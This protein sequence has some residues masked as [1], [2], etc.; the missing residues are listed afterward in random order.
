MRHAIGLTFLAAMTLPVWA[1][2]KPAEDDR[3]YGTWTFTSAKVMGKE[4]P[5]PP[6]A[7]GAF[8]FSKGGKVVMGKKGKS[9]QEGMYTTAPPE[10]G[11]DIRHL[12]LFDVKDGK[13]VE[14]T[15]VKAIYRIEG[16]T[17]TAAFPSGDGKE[18]PTSFDSPDAG[19][20]TFKRQKP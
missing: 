12:D 11:K 5:V 7:E 15:R 6:E 17:L 13:P 1:D 10:G 19:V 9:A 3:L 4:V 8:T 2:N 14:A 20:A 16:D 18:R